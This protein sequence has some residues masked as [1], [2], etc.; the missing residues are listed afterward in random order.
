MKRPQTRSPARLFTKST[1]FNASDYAKAEQQTLD[2]HMFHKR[3]RH[4]EQDDDKL[5]EISE[6]TT[7][8]YSRFDRIFGSL[9]ESRAMP[10]ET[11][12]LRQSTTFSAQQSATNN[13][14]E[15]RQ[16]NIEQT[17][18]IFEHERTLQQEQQQPDGNTRMGIDS[19]SYEGGIDED[20]QR[21]FFHDIPLA[22][23]ETTFDNTQK[24]LFHDIRLA[25]QEEQKPREYNGISATQLQLQA[26]TTTQTQTQTQTQIQI[27][28][29]GQAQGQ[30]QAQSE[31]QSPLASQPPSLPLSQEPIVP[32]PNPTEEIPPSDFEQN[33]LEAQQQMQDDDIDYG[34]GED[35]NDIEFNF[36]DDL[37]KANS[38]H[39]KRLDSPLFDADNDLEDNEYEPM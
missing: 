8:K 4:K 2:I 23:Q 15:R 38:V 11:T 32:I 20:T 25:T 6:L 16:S 31:S 21:S 9:A 17:A 26:H 1:R 22:T 19:S 3:N 33:I 24:S 37:S 7:T 10:P 12:L 39:S 18:P 28:A 27:Q 30:A 29:Q 34:G 5:S 13:E 36:D 14:N 35:Y